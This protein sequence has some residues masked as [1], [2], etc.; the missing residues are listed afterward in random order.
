[1]KT[2]FDG[3]VV[4]AD[5]KK[6][7]IRGGGTSGKTSYVSKGCELGSAGGGGGENRSVTCSSK[8]IDGKDFGEEFEF[9]LEM[10]HA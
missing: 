9:Y 1:M 10:K 6:D 8:R 2:F 4:V 3:S 5:G 7:F